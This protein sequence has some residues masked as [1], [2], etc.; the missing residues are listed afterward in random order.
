MIHLITA[1]IASHSLWAADADFKQMKT[2]VEKAV[3]C[4]TQPNKADATQLMSSVSCYQEVFSEKMNTREQAGMSFW[5]NNLQS[6]K[7]IWACEGKEFQLKS[8]HAKTPYFVCVQ[9]SEPE[10]GESTKLIFFK[11]EKSGFKISSI[12]TPAK[13]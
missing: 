7:K 1:L 13:W 12:Y 5:F 10:K 6:V 3:S 9:L 11:K 2:Q 4:R 8:Y